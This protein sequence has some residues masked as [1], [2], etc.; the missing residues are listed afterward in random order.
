MSTKYF[1]YLFIFITSLTFSQSRIRALANEGMEQAYNFQLVQ[2]EKTYEKIINEFPNSPE[3]YYRTA[4]LHFWIYIGSRDPGEYQVFIKFADIAQEKIDKQLNKN[5]KDYYTNYIA[6]NLMLFRAMA[7]AT[8]GQS[9]DAFWSSKNA[10]NYLEESLKIKPNFYD[11]YLGL[12]LLDYAMSFVPD[13]LKW[14]VNL[15]GLTSDKNRGLRYIKIAYN[16]G[17]YSKTEAQFH[18]AK[19]YS[20]YLSEYD[21]AYT[22]LQ[23]LI[24]KYPQNGLFGYQYAVSLIKGKNVEYANSVLNNVIKLRNK[25]I[26]QITALAYYRKGEIYFK[27]NNFKEAIKNYEMF[28]DLSREL[29]LT[30]IAALNTAISY[31]MLNKEE[32]FKQYL[33]LA[34][35]GNQDIF[36]DTYALKKS[37]NYLENGISDEELFLYKIKNNLDVGN[38]RYVYNTL[39]NSKENFTND[40]KALQLIYLAEAEQ[41]IGKNKEAIETCNEIFEMKIHK[42]KWIMP[43]SKLIYANANFNLGNKEEAKEFLLKAENENDYD[44]KDFIQSKIEFLKRRIK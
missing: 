25:K 35:N 32:D 33:L 43:M 38:Y 5:Q 13:F 4:L 12:G 17:I 44:F 26:P 18:L 10:V 6:G 3:G 42:E 20:D 9:V 27:K 29:D 1:I 8:N 30:G 14:A 23:N 15:T 31:K 41:K 7:Q 21:S 19:I 36:E 37:E 2:A 34:K 16:K 39:T 11:A 40:L 22:L 28:L 24:A